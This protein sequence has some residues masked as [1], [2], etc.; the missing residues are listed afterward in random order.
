MPVCPVCS[1][2]KHSV[3]LDYQHWLSASKNPNEYRHLTYWC[4]KGKHYVVLQRQQ[5]G[6]RD[7]STAIR[8]TI[9]TPV[10]KAAKVA[11]RR[12]YGKNQL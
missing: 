3:L 12:K 9:L 2:H 11:E 1:N 10:G 5:T 4:D 7:L 8:V 6:N